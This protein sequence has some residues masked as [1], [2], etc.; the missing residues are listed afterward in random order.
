MEQTTIIFV[1]ILLVSSCMIMSSEGQ[2]R[3]NKVEECDPRRCKVYTHVI[4]E[5][6]MCTCGHGS[7]IGGNCLGDD[8]CVRD[9]CPPN[10]QVIC[11]IGQCTCVPS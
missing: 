11:D 10:N 9:G 5:N 2:S 1:V 8:Y 6:H 3:C 7:P 4:C